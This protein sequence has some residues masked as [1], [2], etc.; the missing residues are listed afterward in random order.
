MLAQRT[1]GIITLL[2]GALFIIDMAL[3]FAWWKIVGHFELIDLTRRAI[4]FGLIYAIAVPMG[5]LFTYQKVYSIQYGIPNI[6]LVQALGISMRFTF[7]FSFGSLI[8]YF[9]LKDIN[10]NRSMLFYYACFMI[11]LNTLLWR[12]LPK[13][14]IGYFYPENLRVNTVFIGV[15]QPPDC[16][17]SYVLQSAKLGLRFIGYYSDTLEDGFPFPHLGTRQDF[18]KKITADKKI[19]RVLAYNLEHKD[20]Y[21]KALFRECHN[22]GIRIQALLSITNDLNQP[23][24]IN[25]YDGYSFLSLMDEPL[26]NP[27]NRATKRLLDLTIAIPVILFILPPL[28]FCVWFFQRLQAPGPVI[29]RQKRYGHEKETFLIYKFRT[30]HDREKNLREDAQ[31]ATKHD[32]RVYPFGRLLRRMSLDEFPQFYNVIKGQMSIVGPRP[33]PIKLDD[34]LEQECLYYRSRHFTKPGITGYAQI[35]GLRGEIKSKE[36]AEKRHRMDLHYI[37]N[38]SIG[39]DLFILSQTISQLIKPPDAAY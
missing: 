1:K 7:G 24:K 25:N 5:C 13:T 34:R 36:D 2:I 19:Y 10:I 23:I 30:M 28:Y 21:F 37:A 16:L 29:Y 15:D 11:P 3:F 31:Q 27:L 9:A 4:E 33:L 12:F 39:M 14:L 8:I 6:S 32:P 18:L 35:H 20:E 22:R 17:K 26:D 38:W